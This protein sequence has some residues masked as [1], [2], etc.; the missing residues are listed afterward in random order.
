[1]K[2]TWAPSDGG[3]PRQPCFACVPLRESKPQSC[4]KHSSLGFLSLATSFNPNICS[5]FLLVCVHISTLSRPRSSSSVSLGI[6]PF[7]GL[8]LSSLVQLTAGAAWCCIVTC[9]SV[10]R[11]ALCAQILFHSP[12]SVQ[13]GISLQ[14]R[15]Q[16]EHRFSPWLQLQPRGWQDPRSCRAWQ[17]GTRQH[18][19]AVGC[20]AVLIACK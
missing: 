15:F 1:M 4:L 8:T 13:W 20:A 3:A 19:G 11:C 16:R 18:W 2:G 7:V 9:K 5:S 17:R 6:I 12:V 14:S 10:H